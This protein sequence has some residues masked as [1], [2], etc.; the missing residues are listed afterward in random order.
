MSPNNSAPHKSK[1]G[2]SFPEQRSIGATHRFLGVDDTDS[3][4]VDGDEDRDVRTRQPR[5]HP[6][7]SLLNLPVE[8][9]AP[10][11]ER[12]IRIVLEEAIVFDA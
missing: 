4:C 1:K 3:G 12:H 8:E 2:Y 7:R 6:T 10:A 11:R 5:A 9:G